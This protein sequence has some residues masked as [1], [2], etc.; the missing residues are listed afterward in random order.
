VLSARGRELPRQREEPRRAPAEALAMFYDARASRFRSA[1]RCATRRSPTRSRRSRA[2]AR[3]VL[4][5]RQRAGDR[6]EVAAE[7]PRAGGDDRRRLAAYQAKAAPELCGAYRGYR[8]CGMGP[9]SSGA[10]TVYAIL[11]QLER[12]DLG[13]LGKDSPTFWHL[14]AESQRLAYADRERWLADGDFVSV[15]APALMD[16]PTSPR[17][18]R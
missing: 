17:A 8:I 11:K 16:P 5:R 14:F 12:F 18:A 1:P 7:T 10:T 4:H 13:A 3:L 9:P 15:P 6:G 2:T